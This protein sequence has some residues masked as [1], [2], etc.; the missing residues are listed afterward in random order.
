MGPELHAEK[1]CVLIR[2]HLGSV[3][4]ICSNENP[5]N[6]KG[7]RFLTHLRETCAIN[8][9]HMLSDRLAT[10]GVSEFVV[11]EFVLSLCLCLWDLLGKIIAPEMLHEGTSSPC[12]C[13]DSMTELAA[14]CMKRS[15]PQYQ[16]LKL[17]W[18]MPEIFG[19]ASGAPFRK[20]LQTN[21]SGQGCYFTSIRALLHTKEKTHFGQWLSAVRATEL[22]LTARSEHGQRQAMF[23]IISET[24]VKC[25]AGP[26]RFYEQP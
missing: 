4:M 11:D 7:K 20:P 1:I 13:S 6:R 9:T 12:L 2:G 14:H 10:S 15:D 19:L 25:R 21:V 23:S 3:L 22:V 18:K 26:S 16:Q 24:K 17:K 8:R 5:G